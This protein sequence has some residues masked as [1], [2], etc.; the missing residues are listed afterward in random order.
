[1]FKFAIALTS[2]PVTPLS[3][4]AV[5]YI[6]GAPKSVFCSWFISF[7]TITLKASPNQSLTLGEV[8][9]ALLYG[10]YTVEPPYLTPLSVIVFSISSLANITDDCLPNLSARIKPTL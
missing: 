5:A 10:L 7:S 8:C 9:D 6:P 4:V 1:M 2:K 3:D